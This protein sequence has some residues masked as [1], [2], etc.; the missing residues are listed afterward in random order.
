[1]MKI[2]KYALIVAVFLVGGYFF[3]VIILNSVPLAAN[4]N[5]KSQN[6]PYPKP[7]I[8]MA[9]LNQ[10][11]SNQPTVAV[12]DANK[13]I[14]AVPYINESPD[15]N[16]TGN[17]KNACEEAS[18]TMVDKYY[19]GQSSVSSADAKKE[20]TMFFDVQNK[21]WGSNANSDAAR[22]AKLIND[23]TIYNATVIELPTISQ[24]KNELDQSRPVIVPLYGFDLHN[25]NIPFVPLP[26]G[27]SYH[28]LVIIGYDDATKEFI[29]NDDGD[30]KAG[31]GHRYGYDLLMNAIHDYSFVTKQANDTARAIFT[32][33]KLVKLADN[34]RVY[35]LHDNI[36]Q[37]IP[38]EATFK[39]KG[40]TWNEVN[41]VTQVWLDTFKSGD[42]INI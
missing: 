30:T 41:V 17:W 37:Y 14:L 27:T 15:N 18:M 7:A 6:L 10:T 12:K 5:T 42:D 9:A 29:T 28:M 2:L 4:S 35:Y 39:A 40:W 8:N 3:L 19:S 23:N 11:N 20:M 22:T 16:W 26:R 36:K 21:L 33:P 13:V 24:I 1:M 34:P 31:P 32:Y 38:D 25:P